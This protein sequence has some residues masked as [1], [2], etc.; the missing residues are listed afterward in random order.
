MIVLGSHGQ[1]SAPEG[2]TR[3][4]SPRAP[5]HGGRHVA[6]H[7]HVTTHDMAQGEHCKIGRPI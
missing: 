1:L 3:S 5:Q 6:A 2:R 4:P 7:G